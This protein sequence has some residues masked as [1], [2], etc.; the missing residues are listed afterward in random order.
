MNM[1]Y[2]R[3]GDD[4]YEKYRKKSFLESLYLSVIISFC[5]GIFQYFRHDYNVS[6]WK[7]I[8]FFLVMVITGFVI[9]VIIKALFTSFT[10]SFSSFKH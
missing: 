6:I 3:K 2:Y 10:K 1:K 9:I 4:R 7:H 5:I 8:V